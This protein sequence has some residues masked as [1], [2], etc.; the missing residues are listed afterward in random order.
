LS[1][2]ELLSLIAYSIGFTAGIFFCIGT[3]AT[4]ARN[5]KMLT[6]TRLDNSPPWSRALAAQRGLYAA[7][8]LLLVFSFALQVL[9]VGASP[10]IPVILHL[11][12]DTK[13]RGVLVVTAFSLL[14]GLVV[15]LSVYEATIS[16]V[17]EEE[18]RLE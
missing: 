14:I 1:D 17:L 8:G 13:L 12:I 4:S 15:A 6:A 5:I 2:K 16:K 3:V 18:G 7:G 10:A 9:E 11:L